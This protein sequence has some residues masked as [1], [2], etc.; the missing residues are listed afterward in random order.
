MKATAAQRRRADELRRAIHEA[1]EEYYNEG[2]PSLLDSEYDELLRELRELELAHAELLTDDSPTQRVGAPL[3]R[4]SSFEQ[5]QHL[6]PM[7]SI[8]SLTDADQVSEFVARA[9][10]GLELEDEEPLRWAVEPKY[11]GVSA[12]LLYENGQLVRGLSRGDGTTGEDITRNLKTI[13]SIPVAITPPAGVELPPRLEVRGEVIMSRSNFES[14]R[15]R[16]E[17]TTDSGFR[18]PRNTVAGSLKLLD[19]A[20]VARRPIDFIAWGVGMAEGLE[21]ETFGAIHELLGAMGFATAD[22]F[23]L[24]D[25][26]EGVLEYHRDLEA[27]RS[28]LP[29]EMDGVVAKVDAL[30]MQR[31]L[32]RRARAPRWLLAYKFAPQR[33][34][35]RVLSI[36]AQVGRTGAVT[37]VANLEPIELAGVTVSRATLHNWGLVQERDVRVGDAV[38]IERAG[39]VI[40]KVVSVRTDQRGDGS[41][42]TEPP[43]RCPTCDAALEPDKAFLYCVNIECRDQLKGRISHMAGRRALDIDRLGPKYVE[44]LMAAGLIERLEDVFRLPQRQDEIVALEG[45]GERSFQ[46]LEAEIEKAKTPPL[47]RFL[48]AIGIRN[49]GEQTAKDL[50][51]RFGTL[52]AVRA[53]TEEELIAVDGVGEEVARSILAFFALPANRDFLEA[54]H[55]EGLQVQEHERQGGGAFEGR[56]FCF[57][58]GLETMS[59]DEAKALVE[60]R[61]GKTVGSVTKKVTD[62]VA[63]TKAGSKLEK[64]QRLELTI[65][66]EPEF[67]ALVG[68]G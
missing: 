51:N 36:D 58:G 41:R 8:E 48:N 53:A 4:G 2:A 59:R 57:T 11:D 60:E 40:P 63:G 16:S 21:V 65:H 34:V 31:R 49:V 64:A 43:A 61:G 3:P 17:T 46:K 18:N 42:P 9:R 24:V 52:E 13:R 28:D 23:S 55:G 22:P 29:Y 66:T 32:G 10:K 47:A 38:E 56:T 5:A 30:D 62:V 20:I 44:Q 54:A 33:G 68:R 35:T 39:D 19:P 12:N 14:F 27:R 26:A 1:N 50:A 15:T 37:P 6:V 25:T 7:L 67:L 45:W